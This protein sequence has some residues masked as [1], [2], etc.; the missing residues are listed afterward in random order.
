MA[1]TFVTMV[2]AVATVVGVG[3]TGVVT[4]VLCPSD[5]S[6]VLLAGVAS[7]VIVLTVLVVEG[8]VAPAATMTSFAG[9]RACQVSRSS[10]I[11]IVLPLWACAFR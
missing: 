1:D 7:V 4:G 8:E 10:L 2:G 3:G 5:G 6:C 11:V 9:F